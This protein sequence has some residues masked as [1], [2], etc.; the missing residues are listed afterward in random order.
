MPN[1]DIILV[2]G[3][4]SSKTIISSVMGSLHNRVRGVLFIDHDN[5]TIREMYEEMS[6]YS[7]SGVEI[8]D[9]MLH[10]RVLDREKFDNIAKE[11]GLL[12]S[13]VTWEDPLPNHPPMVRVQTQLWGREILDALWDMLPTVGAD[14]THTGRLDQ[15]RVMIVFLFGLTGMTS[16]TVGVEA[17]IVL[18]NMLRS[19]L[20]ND[21]EGDAVAVINSTLD[22]GT[23]PLFV[24]IGCFPPDPTDGAGQYNILHGLHMSSVIKELLAPTSLPRE[25]NMVDKPFNKFMLLDGSGAWR[26]QDNQEDYSE[27]VARTLSTLLTCQSVDASPDDGTFYD[28]IELIDSREPFSHVGLVMAGLRR[29]DQSLLQ[30]LVFV[31]GNATR[32]YTPSNNDPDVRLLQDVINTMN[33]TEAGHLIADVRNSANTW[34]EVHNRMRW[35]NR[36]MPRRR[37]RLQQARSLLRNSLNRLPSRLNEYVKEMDTEWEKWSHQSI[38]AMPAPANLWLKDPLTDTL[39]LREGRSGEKDHNIIQDRN[40]ARQSTHDMV[41]MLMRHLI[42][43]LNTHPMKVSKGTMMLVGST[44]VKRDY[45]LPD[46]EDMAISFGGEWTVLMSENGEM[47]GHPMHLLM[48]WQP[49]DGNILPLYYRANDGIVE[50]HLPAEYRAWPSLNEEDDLSRGTAKGTIL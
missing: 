44:N 29:K 46:K 32:I 2:G 20:L 40:N 33:A 34:A 8:R 3:G 48:W 35:W 16:S 22:R 10:K 49:E 26:T 11:M 37:R 30:T 43:P 45:P 14:D 6:K 4:E 21:R 39:P 47:D 23:M 36:W 50:Q 25:M 24:G 41:R 18:R 12:G 38:W 42:D 19:R 28:S 13:G 9:V 7:G 31:N 5:S 17:A 27:W 15:P 1:R